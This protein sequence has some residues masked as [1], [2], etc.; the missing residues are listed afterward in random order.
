[1]ARKDYYETLGVSH[2]ASP[3]EIKRAYRQKAL[4]FHPDRNPGNKEAEEKFKDAA[5]AYS[6]LIDPQKRSVYDQFGYE[7][8]RGEGYT[9]FTGFNSSVFED[10]EDILGDFFNFGFGDLFGTRQRRRAYYPQKG[11]DLALELEVSLEEAAFGTEKEIKLNKLD[12]CPV[13]HGSKLQPGT[14]KSTCQACQ[15]RGQI[16]YQQGFFTI[17]RTCSHCGGSGEVI[18]S[19]CLECHGSGRIKKKKLL[20][21]KIPAGVDN[22][23]R[24][25]IAGEGEAGDKGAAK[26]DLYV[27]IRVKKHDIFEREG[28]NLYC[29][30]SISFTHA[31]LGTS[32]RIPTLDG[33]EILKIPAGTQAGETFRL[34]GKGIANLESHRK[35]DLFVKI[36]I[37]TPQNLS[38]EQKELLR[39][40]AESRG[41][42]L[43]VLDKSII[44]KVKDIFH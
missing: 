28:N 6:V 20:K 5:E 37:K 32:A 23:T 42:D 7:G 22:A 39:K 4:T 36:N 3:E 14:Q 12:I 44:D 31:A 30:I 24:L 25:R 17:S 15:G 1:M 41:E 34:K 33:F 40:F 35:G 11:R 18:T 8:L 27:L 13:C 21:I 38:Q 43:E 2:D 29:Q 16:R 9:G 10:F 26:V 19:P